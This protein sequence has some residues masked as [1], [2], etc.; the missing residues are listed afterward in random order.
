MSNRHYSSLLREHINKEGKS[1]E[2]TTKRRRVGN[3]SESPAPVIDLTR[4]ESSNQL[5]IN[6]Q[7]ESDLESDEFEDVDIDV[8]SNSPN[9]GDL[10]R[11]PQSVVE[12]VSDEEFD[13]GVDDSNYDYSFLQHASTNDESDNDNDN[14]KQNITI[15]IK[16][17]PLA[18]S[19]KRKVNFIGREERQYRVRMH[20]L[21]LVSMICHGVIRNQ[22][23]NDYDFLVRLRSSIS[24]DILEELQSIRRNKRVSMVNAVRF[25][26]VVRELMFAYSRK[27]RVT[28]Q[29]IVR[30]NWNQLGIPQSNIEKNVGFQKFKKLCLSFQGS[31]DIG[32]QSFVALARSLGMKARLVF[33]VQPPDF[34]MVTE[35]PTIDLISSKTKTDPRTTEG[36]KPLNPKQSFLMQHRTSDINESHNHYKF[37]T[38]SYPVFW[39]EIWNK[40]NRKWLAVDPFTLRVV[41]QPPMRRKSSFEPPMSDPTNNLV[42]A[43]AFDAHG[44]VKDVTRRYAQ[45]Y[46]SRTVKKRI[47][48]KSEEFARW[49]ELVLQ[50]CSKTPRSKLDK[51]DIL[52]LKEFRDRDLTEG[53][54]N[55]AAGFK[56]HPLYALESQLRQNEIINP[57]DNTTKCGSFRYKVSSKSKNTQ[58]VPVYKRSAVQILRSA[59]AWYLRGRVLKIGEQPLKIKLVKRSRTKDDFNDSDDDTNDDD[60]QRLYAESQ[61]KLYIPSPLVL[62]AI[63]K[64]AFGNIDVYVP[65]MVPEGGHLIPVTN[66]YTINLMVKAANILDIDYAKAIVAFDFTKAGGRKAMGRIPKAKEGG[67]VIHEQYKEA[68]EL[69][70]EQLLEEEQEEQ[71]KRVELLSLRGWKLLLTKLRIQNRLD[72]RHGTVKS[73]QQSS[74]KSEG[75]DEVSDEE[76]S[77][78]YSVHSEDEGDDDDDG[79]EEESSKDYYEQGGFVPTEINVPADNHNEPVEEFH[80][81]QFYEH[82]VSD[83]ENEGGGFLN[84]PSPDTQ[85]DITKEDIKEDTELLEIPPDDFTSLPDGQLIYNPKPQL[86][87]NS[88]AHTLKQKAQWPAEFEAQTFAEHDK[89]YPSSSAILQSVPDLAQPGF[90]TSRSEQL[91]LE[92]SE[93]APTL[94][95][96]SFS[97]GAL[98]DT[99]PESGASTQNH[100]KNDFEFEYSD[101]D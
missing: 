60:S 57:K 100:D 4:P 31:K 15:E 74:Y 27:F 66:D 76:E 30:R 61:T 53:M 96:N 44:G 86:S 75:T 73:H 50:A 10:E 71:R 46:N 18:E 101:E 25:T 42:Y 23:C 39:I 79:D 84:E 51:V 78:E 22:W 89:A 37:P 12:G 90:T 20:Q 6:D 80:H 5:Q 47:T 9:L 69:V 28:R 8:R 70:L 91:K 59:K 97:S 2:R 99:G 88:V 87:Q 56:D 34:T 29:G 63:P 11:N 67:V 21:S 43:I 64:N 65:T 17:Q 72:K 52:E 1:N 92:T 58:L 45:Q 81:N 83:D 55:N 38:S 33:S 68:M 26:D 85:A 82:E 13:D 7:D 77:D 14:D 41:E 3:R 24:Q 94:Q 16:G 98:S 93:M 62:G 40:F 95:A 49:Y 32:A 54:P 48:S 19:S 35:L 36:K